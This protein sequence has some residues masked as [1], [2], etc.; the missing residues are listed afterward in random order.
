MAL[1]E[2][3][4]MDRETLLVDKLE[5]SDNLGNFGSSFI[6][7]DSSQHYAIKNTVRQHW[8]ILQNDRVLGPLLSSQ[9]QVIFKGVTFLKD[10]VAISVLDPPV[11]PSFFS[12]LNKIF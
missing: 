8:H 3:R 12:Q 4:N 10:R 11:R 6:T 5:T 7:T 2:V 9:P 1:N